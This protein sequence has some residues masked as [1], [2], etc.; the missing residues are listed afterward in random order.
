MGLVRA[1][2]RLGIPRGPSTLIAASAPLAAFRLGPVG[3]LRA[4]LTWA[5]HMWAYKEAFEIPHD[6]PER[7]RRRLILDWPIAVDARIAPPNPPTLRLQRRFRDP[8]RL[9]ILDY[10][11]TL[12]YAF[13]DLEPHL[14]LAWILARDERRFVRAASRL[15]VTFDLTL[16]GYWAV[17]QAPPWWASEEAGQMGGEV[18]RVAPEVLREL[19]G[20]PRPA[21]SHYRGA[22][23]WAAM[24]SDHFATALMTA[25]VLADHDPRAGLAAA[26]YALLLGFAL[27]YLGEHYVVDLIAG[28]ALVGAVEIALRPRSAPNLWV[29]AVR[30]VCELTARI[31]DL[32]AIA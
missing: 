13:W 15:A 9:T 2:R 16:V 32:R 18:R 22:N 1:R 31:D 8:P 4:A 21:L 27:V 3:K 14:A 11:S 10:L 25:L 7:Q 5:A 28:A 6:V 17:P 12:V 26:T 29:R 24:P 30:R 23:P 19:R 20:R